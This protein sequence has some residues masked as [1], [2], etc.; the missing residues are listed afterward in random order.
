MEDIPSIRA[1]KEE[2]TEI[3]ARGD[4]R[5]IEAGVSGRSGAN[6]TCHMEGFLSC[7]AIQLLWLAI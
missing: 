6:I 2:A 4:A 5:G 7:L 1:N 3:F